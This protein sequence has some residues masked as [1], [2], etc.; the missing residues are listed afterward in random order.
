MEGYGN[1]TYA[2]RPTVSS[3][4]EGSGDLRQVDR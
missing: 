3:R 1:V 2:G 4:Q